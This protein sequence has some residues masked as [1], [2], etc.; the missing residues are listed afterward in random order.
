METIRIATKWG[1]FR[2]RIEVEA[3]PNEI[4]LYKRSFPLIGK[5]KKYATIPTEKVIFWGDN[6]DASQ[7]KWLWVS[8]DGTYDSLPT[9]ND[10]MA[11]DDKDDRLMESLEFSDRQGEETDETL[12]ADLYMYTSTTKL[13]LNSSDLLQLYS[14]LDSSNAVKA[15]V[16]V[17]NGF[18]CWKEYI[19]YTD[20][21]LFHTRRKEVDSVPIKEM[22]F[23]VK[24]GRNLYCGYHRQINVNVNSPKLF[25]EIKELCY[26]K[27]PRLTATG[28]TYKTGLIFPDKI[29]LTDSAVLFTRKTLFKDEMA[30]VPYRRINMVLLSSGLFRKRITIYGEQD[31]VPK[32]AFWRS[33]AVEIVNVLKK[34]GVD[35]TDGIK[36]NSAKIF[37]NN[38]FGRAPRLICLDDC[39]IYE[40]KRIS[41]KVK[42]CKLSYDEISS[43]VW[44]KKTL[45]LFGT[46][47]IMGVAGNIRKDQDHTLVSMVIPSLFAFK[48]KWA[49]FGGK[50]R[51]ILQSKT[52]AKIERVRENYEL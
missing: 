47:S 49:F 4:S 36:F 26:S 28:Q 24:N 5:M 20:K 52:S 1:L 22:A 50:L 16:A 32:H 21:W 40:P 37:P 51:S 17:A 27:A 31:I 14:I 10:E 29:T 13:R 6:D 41:G 15:K 19:S 39:I 46:V 44:Y 35:P 45:A 3:N 12:D 43:V 11:E 42:S 9:Q 18:L 30:Y 23:F 2:T 38:W 7:S 8:E 25:N 33:T 34:H 48:F